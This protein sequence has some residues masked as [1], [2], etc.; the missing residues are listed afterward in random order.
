MIQDIER[1]TRILGDLLAYYHKPMNTTVSD[2]WFIRCNQELTD[3]EFAECVGL[4]L[5]E[6]AYLPPINEF[7]GLVRGDAKALDEVGALEA[8][9]AIEASLGQASSPDY[10]EAREDLIESLTPAQASAL[11]QLG[12]IFKLS[13]IS[14]KDLEWKRKEFLQMVKTYEGGAIAKARSQKF[15]AGSSGFKSL[16]EALF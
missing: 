15:L 8:W 9:G 11:R 10:A 4:C 3:L 5:D 13:M 1:F 14:P 6:K 12:G 16:E 7:I 2:R